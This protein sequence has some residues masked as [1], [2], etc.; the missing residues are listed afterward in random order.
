VSEKKLK[1]IRLPIFAVFSEAGW[2]YER[3]SGGLPT[4]V[5]MDTKVMVLIKV[6]CLPYTTYYYYQ[7]LY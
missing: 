1:K 2:K 4:G 6:D 7:Y 3:F 5:C